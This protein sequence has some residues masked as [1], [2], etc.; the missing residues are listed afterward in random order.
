M[1]ALRWRA[2]VPETFF[3]AMAG[4]KNQARERVQYDLS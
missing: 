2:E 4:N 3:L 1:H